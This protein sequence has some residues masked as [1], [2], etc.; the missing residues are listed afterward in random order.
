[1][2]VLFIQAEIL[3]MKYGLNDLKKTEKMVIGLVLVYWTE[4]VASGYSFSLQ[5]C[6]ESFALIMRFALTS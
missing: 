6:L 3:K 4:Q 1:M 5:S 2:L